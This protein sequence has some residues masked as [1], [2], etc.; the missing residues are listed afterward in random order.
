[1]LA[2]Q[3]LF[4]IQVSDTPSLAIVVTLCNQLDLNLAN[5]ETQLRLDK[6]WSFFL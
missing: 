1:M 5:L 6:F 3:Q 4:I 2:S